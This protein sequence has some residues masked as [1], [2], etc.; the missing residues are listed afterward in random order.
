MTEEQEELLKDY[1]E[2]IEKCWKLAQ[3]LDSLYPQLHGTFTGIPSERIKRQLIALG[4]L[5]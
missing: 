3:R 4:V 5:K 1:Q 2:E